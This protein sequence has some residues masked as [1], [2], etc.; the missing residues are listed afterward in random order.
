M[1]LRITFHKR[2]KDEIE[3]DCSDP[4]LKN[5]LQS[6]QIL[7]HQ[8]WRSAIPPLVGSL[9]RAHFSSYSSFFLRRAVLSSTCFAFRNL[10]TLHQCL[11]RSSNRAIIINYKCLF[12]QILFL[13]GP[14]LQT[15]SSKNSTS[16]R[17][18][19]LQTKSSNSMDFQQSRNL[20]LGETQRN[21]FGSGKPT[22]AMQLATFS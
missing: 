22:S 14:W 10:P 2:Q 15:N 7:C 12:V 18:L 21:T 13:R 5:Q 1:T 4:R 9:A 19:E 3:I 11:P 20:T 6:P 8:G 17:L 16:Q